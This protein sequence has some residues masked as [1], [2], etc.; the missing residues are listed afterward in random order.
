MYNATMNEE[1]DVLDIWKERI[2]KEAKHGDKTKA[3]QIVG[4][5]MT[6]YRNALL[7]EK[8]TDLKDGELEMLQAL[9]ERLDNRKELLQKIQSKYAKQDN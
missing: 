6:T 7:R 4:T 5:T 1:R 8:F 2:K 3:C 9:I